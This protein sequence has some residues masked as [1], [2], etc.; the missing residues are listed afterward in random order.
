MQG[1]QRILTSDYGIKVARC[2]L[3][4]LLLYCMFSLTMYMKMKHI[5]DDNVNNIGKFWN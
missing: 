5:G 1:L 4:F 3:Y 2:N